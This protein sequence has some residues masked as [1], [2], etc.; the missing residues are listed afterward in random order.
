MSRSRGSPFQ[1]LRGAAGILEGDVAGEGEQSSPGP[2]APWRPQCCRS[3]SGTPPGH[4]GGP[5]PCPGNPCGRP[6][7]GTMA[8][9]SSSSA[10]ESW[11][12][13]HIPGEGPLLGGLD[14]VVVQADLPH[15]HHLLVGAHRALIWSTW[16]G[17]PPPGSPGDSRR[18]RRGRGIAPPGRWTA[19]RIPGRSRGRPPGPPPAPAGRTAARPGP[20]RRRRRSNGAW[21]SKIIAQTSQL[22]G[23]NSPPYH[24]A[25]RGKIQGGG[26]GFP[27]R[28]LV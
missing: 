13:K 14:P 3:S 22:D 20:G 21:V 16:A 1:D 26:A 23:S 11:G 4:W 24:S 28:L 8:G 6:G 15:R 12:V 27:R 25:K 10:R 18:R 17:S 19:P 9:R 7:R 2:P 5:G